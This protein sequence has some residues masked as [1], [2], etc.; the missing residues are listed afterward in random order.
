MDNLSLLHDLLTSASKAGATAADAVLFDTTDI[1]YSQRMG[2][3]EGL[4]RSE[5]KGIGLRVFVGQCQAFVS[6]TDTSP[7]TLHALAERAVTMAKAS[8]ADPFSALAPQE[9]L[10]THCPELDLCDPAGEPSAEWVKEQCRILED[11]ALST[12]GITNSEGADAHFSSSNIALATSHGFARQYAATSNSL[13]I[14]VLAGSGTEMERDYAFSSARYTSDLGAPAAIGTD[15]AKRALARINPRKIDTKKIPI[16]F[17]PRVSKSLVGA[18]AGAIS[19]SAISRG[20]SFLKDALGSAV[21]SSSVSIIDD[22]HIKRGL[23]S[24]PFD[25][26]GVANHKTMLVDNGILTTWLLDVRSANKLGLNTT[27][28]AARG[29]SSP[30]SPSSS[31]LYMQAGTLTPDELM[32]DITEGLYVTDT[33]GMGVNMITGDY[34]QGASGFWISGGEIAYPVSEI[35]IAGHLKDMFREMTAANDLEFKYGTNA[36]T[37]RIEGMTVAGK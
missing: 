23:A 28:H 15:A 33:F 17:D 11:T 1:S 36:P 35:T 7:N 9:R 10:A 12:Q 18:L 8:P 2:K 27:G 13:S 20:T 14:S 5:S 31:N 29:L 25:A 22:P 37:L 24:R 19:G 16:L 4:E 34:S 30:P 32:A 6:S 3:P 21:F 26:E